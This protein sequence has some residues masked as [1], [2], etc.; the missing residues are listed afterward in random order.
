MI[1]RF[2]IHSTTFVYIPPPSQSIME[3][4]SSLYFNDV[5]PV[6]GN[7]LNMLDDFKSYMNSLFYSLILLFDGL[8]I[9]N[10]YNIEL[11]SY[12]CKLHVNEFLDIRSVM[13]TTKSN[14]YTNWLVEVDWEVWCKPDMMEMRGD[15]P[16]VEYIISVLHRECKNMTAFFEYRQ[17]L[18]LPNKI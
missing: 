12:M 11:N 16:L 15:D 6:N 2:Q 13:S 3:K 4:V 1:I 18:I 8:N 10:K 5:I 7:T 14:N 9:D 17:M